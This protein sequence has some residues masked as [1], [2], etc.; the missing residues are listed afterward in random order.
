VL[1]VALTGYGGTE[2]RARAL[3]CGFD[4]HVVKPIDERGLDDLLRATPPLPRIAPPEEADSRDAAE[5]DERV[6]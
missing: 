1:L 3:E 5:I 4:R 6:R 2:D